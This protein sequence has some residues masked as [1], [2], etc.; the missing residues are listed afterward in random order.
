MGTGRLY[1]VATP[2]GNLGDLSERAVETLRQ[3]DLVVAEDT[4]RARNLLAHLGLQKPLESF[5]GDSDR[6]KLERLLRRLSD[7]LTL[8]VISDGGVPGIADPRR[9]VVAAAHEAGIPVIPVPGPCALTTALCAAG[10]VADRFVFAGFPPRKAQ[11][12]RE[13]LQHYTGLGLTCVLYEAPHRVAA[14]LAALA[15]VC[16][17]RPVCI[18]R[19]LTKLHEE[20]LVGTAD[21]LA[22]HFRTNEPRGEFVLV[23][24]GGDDEA[25]EPDMGPVCKEIARMVARGISVRDTAD[26]VS[27][28]TAMSRRQAYE[29]ALAT[30]E[31]VLGEGRNMESGTGSSPDDSS[32]PDLNDTNG[33]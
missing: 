16:P 13:F 30:R 5:H 18:G 9:E 32:D 28:L 1:M 31:E 24:A 19:E 2:I 21:E 4:R 14:T 23:V 25:V 15:E 6:R 12:Q 20:L 29:I 33:T 8:A 27:A 17:G 3:A 22:E 7:G 11:E 26:T 10:F